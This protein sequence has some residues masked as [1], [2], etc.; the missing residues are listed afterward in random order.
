M[1]RRH[2]L[3][4]TACHFEVLERRVLF[5]LYGPDISFGN[6]GVAAGPAGNQLLAELPDGKILAV[7]V[8]RI[9]VDQD[10][11]TARDAHRL[12][13][14]GTIDRTFANG[15][16]V[17]SLGD[18]GGAILAG[19]RFCATVAST[20]V[21][22]ADHDRVVAYTTDGVLDTAFSGDGSVP[23][24]STMT[25]DESV[26]NITG[27]FLGVAPGG[28]VVLLV[29]ADDANG[30][31][32]EEVAKLTS[33]GSVDT[34]FGDGGF[35]RLPADAPNVDALWTRNGVIISRTPGYQQPADITYTR[36]LPDGSAVD[37]TFG[38]GGTVT[39][40]SLVYGFAEQ[41]DG[42][43]LIVR[44]PD[45]DPQALT[46]RLYRL[47]ADGSPTPASV[48]PAACRWRTRGSAPR[49]RR[50]LSTPSST[51]WSTPAGG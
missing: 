37:P 14:D 42:K 17:I 3:A 13:P 51:S 16:G 46:R 40:P 47:N 44:S 5:V 29:R 33:D 22:G 2:R 15:A 32:Y 31:D 41:P 4:P 30:T 23:L 48:S 34:T 49:P 20:G 10:F 27:G 28:G 24:P 36:Y 25:V 9:S 50:C 43:L 26:D 19:T 11:D 35:L 18:T 6:G 45:A 21:A 39:F 8:R 7:G 1:K 12:N 38:A